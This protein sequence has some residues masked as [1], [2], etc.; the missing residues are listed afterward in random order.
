ML[1]KMNGSNEMRRVQCPFVSE[2]EVDA[3]TNFLRTQGTPT[4]HDAI[5]QGGDDED[6]EAVE[7]REPTDP[8]LHR[9]GATWRGSSQRAAVPTAQRFLAAAQDDH[10]LQP[11]R[12]DRRDDGSE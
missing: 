8:R 1:V 5:L 11:G 6:E 12:Q 3:L 2:E 9:T 10:R 7:M 4:Y